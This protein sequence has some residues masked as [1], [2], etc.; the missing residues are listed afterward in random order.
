M[1]GYTLDILHALALP[2]AVVYAAGRLAPGSRLRRARRA[3]RRIPSYTPYEATAPVAWIDSDSRHARRERKR[4]A[5]IAT[6]ERRHA[7][8]PYA[9]DE[10]R[11]SVRAPW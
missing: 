7:A 5:D 4:L 3:A 10:A 1:Y 11:N 9:A 8:T 6:M 2:L